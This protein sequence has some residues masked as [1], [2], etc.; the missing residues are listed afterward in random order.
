[1][2]DD[3]GDELP[4]S[5]HCDQG[6]D[7]V[8]GGVYSFQG[9]N[10]CTKHYQELVGITCT[11]CGCPIKEDLTLMDYAPFHIE[12]WN[13]RSMTSASLT[14]ASLMLDDEDDDSSDEEFEAEAAKVEGEQQLWEATAVMQK[15]NFTGGGRSQEPRGGMMLIPGTPAGGQRQVNMS[16]SVNLPKTPQRAIQIPMI[17]EDA[18]DSTKSSSRRSST[19][20]ALESWPATPE[21][22]S[23]RLERLGVLSEE[24]T[25]TLTLASVG[26]HNQR[27]SED[28]AVEAKAAKFP[29][30][31][32]AATEPILTSSSPAAAGTLMDV[33]S[34][35]KGK[36]GHRRQRTKIRLSA[37]VKG[38]QSLESKLQEK[39]KI[40]K[41]DLFKLLSLEMVLVTPQ[42]SYRFEQYLAKGMAVDELTFIRAVAQ[43]RHLGLIVL[44]ERKQLQLSAI[45]TAV[46][47][48]AVTFVRDDAPRLVNLS[49]TVR[50]KLLQRIQD[51]DYDLTLFDEAYDEVSE[52]LRND[53]FL[54]WVQSL[55]DHEIGPMG[56][57]ELKMQ[58]SR[59]PSFSILKPRVDVAKLDALMA[60]IIMTRPKIYRSRRILMQRKRVVTGKQLLTWLVDNEV[61]GTQ[62]HAAMMATQMLDCSLIVPL[63]SQDS[64]R[65]EFDG[66]TL[67]HLAKPETIGT[68]WP[69][70]EEL[71]K[72]NNT[73]VGKLLL[74]TVDRYHEVEG[75]LYPVS[76][77]L[78]L[79]CRKKMTDKV[80]RPH[81]VINLKGAKAIL[82]R[83]K[84]Q[85][86]AEKDQSG[87][88]SGSASGSSRKLKPSK[89]RAHKALAAGEDTYLDTCYIEITSALGQ[90]YLLA[91]SKEEAA[92]GWRSALEAMGLPISH[93]EWDETFL[94]ADF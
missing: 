89:R 11:D 25:L 33:P 47:A 68:T 72:A 57:G 74:K 36:P 44:Q 61:C 19:T 84:S 83:I 70:Y 41:D 37:P 8:S 27:G 92:W 34:E 73:H 21:P 30:H 43:F 65:I 6:H 29:S 80:G 22:S 67:F 63:L 14:G 45:V 52:T 13:R 81:S 32:R 75:V 23:K 59:R 87:S 4:S 64:S 51:N 5:F 3:D 28:Q 94:L 15:L 1:M 55:E 71:L 60:Q 78:F 93:K 56:V 91:V 85:A 31:V 17:K 16:G 76:L 7:I 42:Y 49:G 18:E 46:R 38:L 20:S 82:H 54:R 26:I 62:L 24:T 69:A 35:V 48:I 40:N 10:L 88:A 66:K 53:A 79:F 9:K 50:N 39:H 58:S 90:V 2:T 77:K 86:E 12:C